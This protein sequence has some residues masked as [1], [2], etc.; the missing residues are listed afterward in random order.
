[1]EVLYLLEKLKV[2]P[3]IFETAIAPFR[4]EKET[5]RAKVQG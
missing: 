3:A 4:E 1:M 5:Y 2:D